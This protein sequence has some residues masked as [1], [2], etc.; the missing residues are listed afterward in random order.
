M[1]EISDNILI[2]TISSFKCSIC[3]EIMKPN[4]IILTTTKNST[5][6]VHTYLIE[7]HEELIAIFDI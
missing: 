7:Q 5:N 6:V 4:R 2:T 1:N 3:E